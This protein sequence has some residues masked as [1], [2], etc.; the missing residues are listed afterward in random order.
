MECRKGDRLTIEISGGG[1]Y[2]EPAR[3]D[4][5]ALAAD[6]TEGRVSWGAPKD[7]PTQVTA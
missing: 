2:G 3:R 4:K 5:R 7:L 1:G 6:I